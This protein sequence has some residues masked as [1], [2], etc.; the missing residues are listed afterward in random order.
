MEYKLINQDWNEQSYH[1]LRRL[2]FP[3]HQ[4][5]DDRLSRS[6]HSNL[7]YLPFQR[8]PEFYIQDVCAHV[9]GTSWVNRYISLEIYLYFGLSSDRLRQIEHG[10]TPATT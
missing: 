9:T 3:L 4:Q 8:E 1:L 7:T 5:T 2:V 6:L 10:K